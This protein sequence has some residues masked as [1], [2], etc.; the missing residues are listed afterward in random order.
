MITDGLNPFTVLLFLGSILAAVA[1]T[2]TYV[3]AR[4]TKRERIARISLRAL[5]G[6]V[7][8]YAILLICFSAASHSRVL[9]PG[10]EKHICEVDCHLAYSVAAAKSETLQSGQVRHVV[11]VK[12]R[13]DEQTIAPWRPKDA[14]LSPNSRYVALVDSKGNRY[15]GSID[16][17]KRRL[18]P[19]E[20][21]TTDLVFDIPANAGQVRLIL[22]NADPESV[23]IIGHE[24]SF[25]HGKTTF[26]LPG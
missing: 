18:I 5:L 21:Y 7:G 13:F 9:A 10:E 20:S 2:V 23:F 4:V 3:F 11:T 22:R 16:G 24:N 6:G 15:V 17:L 25:W 12:V 14:S 1:L 8:A 26:Q 19:G